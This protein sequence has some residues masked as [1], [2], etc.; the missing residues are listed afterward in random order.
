[1][2]KGTKT[3]IKVIALKTIFAILSFLVAVALFAFLTN[4]I[5][6]KGKDDFDHRVF[7]YLSGRVSDSFIGIMRFFTFF[8]KPEFMIPAYL[9]LI[10]WFAL[11]KKKTYA[12]EVFIM[13]ASSTALL[14][15]LKK[16][17]GRPRPEQPLF[18][19]L[20]GYSFPS[21]HALLTFVFCSVVI[22]LVWQ[23]KLS[24][25]WKWIISVLLVLFSIAVGVSRII[26][27]VHYPTDV[28]A[29]FAMGYIWVLLG[30]WV[31][32]KYITANKIRQLS[33]TNAA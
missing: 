4:H 5:I 25:L 29:G 2:E 15:A 23:S 26:L 33:K 16:I 28:I 20:S 27:R 22:Y 30:L 18:E 9:L 21:G 19:Y 13:G 1:M 12:W 17:F 8:G 14:F 3:E 31:Q 10:A 6:F 11:R 24:D 7:A 32:H